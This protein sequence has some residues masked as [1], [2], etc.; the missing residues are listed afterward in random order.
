LLKNIPDFFIRFLLQMMAVQRRDGDE[1]LRD[2]TTDDFSI[3]PEIIF[4]FPSK[5]IH[6]L[7]REP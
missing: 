3:L 1:R 5:E 6:T 7:R 4:A 2:D